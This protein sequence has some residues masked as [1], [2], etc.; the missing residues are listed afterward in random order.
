MD[1]YDTGA[2]S[3]FDLMDAVGELAPRR[4]KRYFATAVLLGFLV[5][6]NQASRALHWYAQERAQQMVQELTDLTPPEQPSGAP[7]DVQHFTP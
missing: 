1:C 4:W 3:P 5:Y 6:P 2:M 7:A